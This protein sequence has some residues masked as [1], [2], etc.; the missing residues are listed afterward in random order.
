MTV[1]SPLRLRGQPVG[2][3]EGYIGKNCSRLDVSE[4]P[5]GADVVVDGR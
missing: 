1:V 5:D 2:V 4:L 3:I